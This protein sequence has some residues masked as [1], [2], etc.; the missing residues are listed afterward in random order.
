MNYLSAENLSKSTGERW[1]FKNITFG[2]SKGDK[3][4]LVGRNGTGKT[5]LMDVLAGL[6]T[7]E[8]GV[9][10]I[11]KEVRLG[12]LSQNPALDENQTVLDILFLGDSPLLQAIRS[13]EK[14]LIDGNDQEISDAAEEMEA[15]K[16]WDYESKVKQVL[17]RLG[18]AE[19]NFTK[20]IGQLSGGQRKRVALAKVLLEEPDLLILDEPTNHLDLEAIEWLEN[21]LGTAN[22]TLLLVTHDRYFLDRVCNEI[23]EL[24]DGSIYRYKGNYSYFL[25]R[26]SERYASEASSVDKAQNLLRKELEWMRRQPKARGTKAQYRIDAFYDLQ[27]KA[28]QG[29]K[30]SNVE[31]N[32]GMARLGSKIIELDHIKK[33]FG[34]L[35]IVEDFQYIFRRRERIGIVGKNGVGKSTFL[36]ILTGEQQADSGEISVGE[37]VRFGYYTQSEPTFLPGQ[38]VIDVV[39]DIAEVV[40]LGSGETITASQFLQHFLFEPKRQYTDVKKL[41]GGE[42]RRL[43]LLQVLIKNPNFLILDEPT[44]DLDIQTLNVLEDY[45]LQF[46]GCLV[47]VSHDRY[48]M[49]R[50]VEHLFVFEGQGKIRD[51]PGNY[52]D[53]RESLSNAAP[54]EASK[55]KSEAPKTEPVPAAVTPAPAKRK[56]S[57]KEQK[58]LESLDKEIPELE[59]KRA[60]LTEQMNSG[61]A[62]YQQIALWAKEIEE[63]NALLEDKEFRWME[64]SE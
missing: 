34:P 19:E 13:Y 59:N 58:E 32:I 5:S 36:D 45:L 48:F 39:K 64:L 51:F 60:V 26:Q 61:S 28:N 12:Y 6:Q 30:E 8:E 43:Q 25:E 57:F 3:V 22:T 2:L 54:V 29:R 18:V 50:L 17:G 40:T 53:Y 16:A 23:L 20:L 55:P 11:R 35:K 10:S 38:R 49:D 62:D 1:L 9:I 47:L 21:Y 42:K 7:A 56:L 44:N 63:I 41:S 52:T 24:A 37:T 27:D 31:L 33:A 4:A 15:Q 14:S 46:S